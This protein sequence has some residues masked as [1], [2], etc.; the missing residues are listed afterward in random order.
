M[1]EDVVRPVVDTTAI[2]TTVSTLAAWLP[3]IASLFTIVWMSMR[4]YEMVT[5]KFFHDSSLIKSFRKNN[6]DF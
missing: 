3:P 2:V 4:I 5:G 6:A 1:Y